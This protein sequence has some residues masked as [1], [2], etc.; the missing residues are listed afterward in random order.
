MIRTDKNY[1]AG[2]GTVFQNLAKLAVNEAKPATRAPMNAVININKKGL[3]VLK[4]KTETRCAKICPFSILIHKLKKPHN[5]NSA[6][7]PQRKEA[8]GGWGKRRETTKATIAILHQGKYK[9]TQKLKSMMR[10]TLI[11]NFIELFFL[12]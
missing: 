4:I 2:L 1:A 3:S 7:N 12:F 5:N 6:I 11:I 8:K 9:Q 10:I